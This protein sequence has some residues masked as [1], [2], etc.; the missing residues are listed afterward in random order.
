MTRIRARREP[1]EGKAS[2]QAMGMRLTQPTRPSD[3]VWKVFED[4]VQDG[5]TFREMTVG[6]E[7]DLPI[8]RVEQSRRRKPA[9]QPKNSIT[10]AG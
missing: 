1:S 5:N 9:T 8:S 4:R 7:A 6:S 2:T 10:E 3:A